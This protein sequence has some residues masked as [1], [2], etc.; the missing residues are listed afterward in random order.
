MVEVFGANYCSLH[1]RAGNYAAFHLYR[2]TLAFNTHGTEPK[3]YADGEDA[4]DMVSRTQLYWPSVMSS[5]GSMPEDPV[6]RC[7]LS[8]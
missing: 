7:L 5:S 1:V 3:Y 6:M 2:D 8:A 4:F